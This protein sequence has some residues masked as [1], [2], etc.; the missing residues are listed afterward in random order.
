GQ[1]WPIASALLKTTP[2]RVDDLARRFTALPV[3]AWSTAPSAAL[4][5]PLAS[6]DQPRP[7]G[8]LI[9][10]LSPHRAFDA[11]YRSFIELAAA[12]IVTAIRNATAYQAERRRA[13]Q[14]AEIDRAKTLF[15]SNVSHEFRTPLTLML[16]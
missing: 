9:A 7:Y 8:V 11:G 13:E 6:P 14:L 1:A 5:L 4:A 10:G 2:T 3:G 12:Q 15:F 16:G